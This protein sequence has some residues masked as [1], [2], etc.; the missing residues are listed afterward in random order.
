M[1]WTLNIGSPFDG[2][3]TWTDGTISS[4]F[5]LVADY[6]LE[7]ALAG[8]PAFATLQSSAIEADVKNPEWAALT[9][10]HFFEIH[11][12]S[13]FFEVEKTWTNDPISEPD[14]SPAGTVY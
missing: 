11:L 1:E 2:N 8:T 14:D 7:M 5:D 3:V 4:E 10:L 13:T 12:G 6:V 9:V